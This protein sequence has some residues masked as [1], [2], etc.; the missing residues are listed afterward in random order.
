MSSSAQ[1]VVI[2]KVDQDYGVLSGANVSIL[3]KAYQLFG[4]P[5]QMRY[6]RTLKDV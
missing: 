1:L 3:S 6:H 2:L 4:G 5:K